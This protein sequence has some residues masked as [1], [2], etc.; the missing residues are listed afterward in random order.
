M[1][2]PDRPAAAARR[3]VQVLGGAPDARAAAMV[4]QLWDRWC[5]PHRGYHDGRH[6]S[7]CLDAFAALARAEGLGERERALGALALW[8]HDAVYDVARTDNEAASAAL[9]T[10]WLG[11]ELTLAAADVGSVAELV[12]L[13]GHH[14]PGPD[15]L[16]RAVSD[17]DLWILAAPAARF[18]GYCA[19]VRSEYA[20]V[21]DAEYAA[22]R[23]EI[24]ADLLAG[25]VYATAD[26]Q[27]RWEP[28]ARANLARELA[29]LSP[30]RGRPG[31]AATRRAG[32][33]GR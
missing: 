12:A 11:G 31:P 22:R 15:P 6:L 2:V 17:A 21:G 4:A 25:S 30:R 20:H 1:T 24:L 16:E 23:A 5:E 3:A 7:E 29:R 10:S 27:R 28:A 9:A 26:A 13:T 18:D 32:H 8:F 33:S 19:D 14:R